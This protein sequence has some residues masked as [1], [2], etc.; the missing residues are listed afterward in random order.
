MAEQRQNHRPTIGLIVPTL[1][2]RVDWW[3]G[4]GEAAR[5]R[6][7]NLITFPAGLIWAPTMRSILH[8]LAG[9]ENVDGLVIAQ[10]W[11]SLDDF[12]VAYDRFYRPLPVA[13][14]QRLYENQL[15]V[16]ADNYHGTYALMRH[17]IEEHHYRHIAFLKGPEGNP[18]ADSRYQAYCDGL[19][20]YGLTLDPNLVVPGRFAMESGVAAMQTLLDERHCR[21]VVDF[22]AIVAASDQ[23]ALGAFEVLQRRGI[24]VPEDVALVGFDDLDEAALM[25]SPLTTARMPNYEM[26]RRATEMLLD[27]LAGKPVELHLTVPAQMIIRESC[28]CVSSAMREVVAGE[29]IPQ[30]IVTSTSLDV[31]IAAHRERIVAA[32]RSAVESGQDTFEAGWADALLD[33]LVDDVRDGGS[34]RFL[35]VLRDTVQRVHAAGIPVSRWH[36][37]LSV[38]RC[39]VLPLLGADATRLHRAEDLWQQGRVMLAEVAARIHTRE[40]QVQDQALERLHDLGAALLGTFDLNEQMDVLAGQLEGLGFPSYYLVLYA[41]SA[42]PMEKGRLIMAYN[43]N[44]RVDLPSAGVIFPTRHLLPEGILPSDQPQNLIIEPLYFQEMHLGYMVFGRAA[45]R[46]SDYEVLGRQISTA[47]QGALV[48]QAQQAAERALRHQ[49]VQRETAAEVSQVASS[50]LAPDALIR[51]VVNLIRERFDLYYAGLFLVDE[52][53]TLSG[54]P[55]G[56]WAVLQAGTGDAGRAMLDAGHKLE[57]GGDSMIGWCIANKRAR[58]ALDVGQEAVRFDNP[59]LPETRSELALPLVSRGVAIGALTIQSEREAAFTEADVTVLQTMADQLA[60]AIQNASLLA[61]SQ[62]AVRELEAVQRRY[63]QRA[64]T[65]YVQSLAAPHYEAGHTESEPLGDAVLP[66]IQQAMA[67]KKVTALSDNDSATPHAALVAPITQRGEVV[68][69]ALGI[70]DEAGRQWT[71]DEIALV[72]A[73]AER[74]SLAAENLRLLDE[75]QRRAVREQLVSEVTARI[76]TPMDMNAILQAAVRE[77]GQAMGVERV[78]VYLASAEDEVS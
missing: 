58:I 63:E 60:N 35:D 31:T 19:E 15:G 23:I 66:E 12:T 70:H 52:D 57:V 43:E 32:L 61:R 55:G 27:Q 76:R 69:G 5:A 47:L 68:I 49:A 71:E 56:K 13:N 3:I 29:A 62:A 34:T 54:E 44:G 73:V 48:T 40:R 65:D 75:T 7:A 37:L 26:G 10:W 4:A 25:P 59:Y 72:E 41:D 46:V 50:I 11:P 20:A 24:R 77:L 22:D 18:S 14:I 38:L 16:I 17:L 33:A 53:G 45:R 67:E 39:E 64:W 8:D 36:T 21:P 28:G 2:E 9:A 74:M 42:A 78:S 6:G 1:G 30:P 51:R